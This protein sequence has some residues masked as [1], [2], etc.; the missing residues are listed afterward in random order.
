MMAL[1]NVMRGLNKIHIA[2]PV[3]LVGIPVAAIIVAPIL[4]PLQFISYLVHVV[5]VCYWNIQRE[6]AF[7]L[8]LFV[9]TLALGRMIMVIFQRKADAIRRLVVFLVMHAAWI[10]VCLYVEKNADMAHSILL[11]PIPQSIGLGENF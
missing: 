5:V 11:A 10:G 7:Y 8:R 2:L 4:F 3:L 9:S 6:E 1:D